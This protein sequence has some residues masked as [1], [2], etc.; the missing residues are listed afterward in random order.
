M[1]VVVVSRVSKLLPPSLIRLFVCFSA[2]F[3]FKH[4]SL[5]CSQDVNYESVS[6]SDRRVL[7]VYSDSFV[8]N[9]TQLAGC[10]R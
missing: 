1:V 9:V 3:R 7:Y 8:L 4:E 10:T 5:A 6:T 2:S